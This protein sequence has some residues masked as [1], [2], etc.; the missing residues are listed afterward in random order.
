MAMFRAPIIA[1]DFDGTLC[2]HKYPCIGEENTYILDQCKKAKEKGAILILWT[3]RRDRK[4][5]EAVEWCR[6]RG[7]TFD[8]VNENSPIV[9]DWFG[10]DTRK[11]CADIY[12]DDKNILLSDNFLDVL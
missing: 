9:L 6:Q 10:G 7:L 11:I 8:Y 2:E 1:V 4:L 5:D 3:C 12:I